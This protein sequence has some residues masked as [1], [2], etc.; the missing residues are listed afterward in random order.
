LRLQPAFPRAAPPA[1]SPNSHAPLDTP[2]S[3]PAA[4]VHTPQPASACSYCL[5]LSPAPQQGC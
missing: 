2:H 1:T 3:V 4:G 5:S